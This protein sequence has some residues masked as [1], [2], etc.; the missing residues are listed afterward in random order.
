MNAAVELPARRK[1]LPED[2]AQLKALAPLG[3]RELRR[4]FPGVSDSAIHGRL[5]A[6]GCRVPRTVSPSNCRRGK[7]PI[8]KHAHPLVRR[9]IEE[10][11]RQR[12]FLHEVADAAGIK[13]QT[14]SKWRYSV[15]P[16]FVLFI[17]AA[18]VLGLELRLIENNQSRRVCTPMPK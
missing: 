3:I 9:L 12:V 14:I 5:R 7:I 15:N 13:R 11:N 16:H 18:N 8:P 6:M 10:C 1:W 17:A 4:A 2:K